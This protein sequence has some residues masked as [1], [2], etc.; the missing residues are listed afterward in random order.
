MVFLPVCPNCGNIFDI[1]KASA[2]IGGDLSS[3]SQ[4][5]STSYTENKSVDY[6]A[7][8]KMILDNKELD[9]EY[10]INVS[11]DDLIKNVQYKKLKPKQKEL[12]YNKIQDLLPVDKKKLSADE[13]KEPTEIAYFKCVNCGLMKKVDDGTRLFS[14]VSNDIAQGY[15]TD[16]VKDML[17]SNIIPRTRK[18]TCPNGDC[19][20]HKDVTKREAVFFRMNNKYN[21]RYICTACETSF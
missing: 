12:V 2:Q 10:F 6:T 7:L 3:E 8:I 9:S 14:R 13:Q 11:V 20:S 15:V 1:T 16:D 21:I 5:T 19:V 18:Y 4:N 17:Y